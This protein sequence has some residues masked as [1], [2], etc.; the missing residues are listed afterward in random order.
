MGVARR[1]G[2][3]DEVV[4][5][6]RRQRHLRAQAFAR[7]A[8]GSWPRQSS[9]TS[10]PWRRSRMPALRRR[11]KRAAAGSRGRRAGRRSDVHALGQ[12]RARVRRA[13]RDDWRTRPSTPAGALPAGAAATRPPIEC[14]TMA[15]SRRPREQCEQRGQRGAVLGD[16]AA[17]VVADVDGRAAGQAARRTARRRAPRRTPSRPAR[18]GRP[19][20]AGG[21]KSS[22]AHRLAVHPDGHPTAS[23]EPSRS[24]ASP[25]SPLSAAM[26]A[27]PRGVAE[28]GRSPAGPPTPRR[29]TARA[30]RRA[31]PR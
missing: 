21:G 23:G 19:P 29:A 17:G 1:D 12:R 8:S 22:V 20:A 15:I 4:R 24:S 11:R 16:V 28:G 14:P 3:G 27:A 9:S 7:S 5:R 26:T 31:T 2:G 10:Q 6:A 30:G 13:Q 25:N 18:A